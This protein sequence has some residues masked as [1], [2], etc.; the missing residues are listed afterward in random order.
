MAAAVSDFRPAETAQ[1]KVKKAAGDDGPTLRLVQ[2]PDFL[3]EVPDSIVKVGFAAESEDLLENARQK[4]SSKRLDLIAANDIT[5]TDSGFGVDSNRV[6][7]LDS[8]GG[9]EEVPLCSKYEVGHR[10]L[11]RVAALLNGKS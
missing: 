10:I 3:L 11:D 2:N 1:H 7:I 9:T 4:L 6:T 5:A 8:K